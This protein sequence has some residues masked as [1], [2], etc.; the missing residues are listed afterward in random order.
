MVS[1]YFTDKECVMQLFSKKKKIAGF[2]AFATLLKHKIIYVCIN[3]LYKIYGL[4]FMFY[5]LYPYS[6]EVAWH[7]SSKE[8]FLDLITFLDIH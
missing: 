7:Y 8:F 3:Q 6:T 2:Q 1:T 5:N 4:Q